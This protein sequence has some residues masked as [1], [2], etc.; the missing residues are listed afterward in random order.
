MTKR[1]KAA[2]TIRS[3]DHA[4]GSQASDHGGP[5][6]KRT[7]RLKST[8]TNAMLPP[9]HA[10]FGAGGDSGTATDSNRAPKNK[11]QASLDA[12]QRDVLP[13]SRVIHSP[14]KK[15]TARGTNNGLVKASPSKKVEAPVQ[16]RVVEESRPTDG[17]LDDTCQKLRELQRRK[18]AA[19]KARIA[20]DNQ[21]TALVAIELGYSAGLEE[22]ERKVLWTQARGV[23]KTIGDGADGGE[24]ANVIRLVGSVV[25]ATQHASDGFDEYLGRIEKEMEGLAKTLPVLAWASQQRGFGLLSLAAIVGEC[26]NIGTYSG[27]AALQSRLGLAPIQHNGVTRMPSTW[28][29]SRGLPAE[30][31]AE[32]GYSPRRRSIMYVIGECLVKQNKGEFRARY[33]Q[34]K[35]AAK[36]KHENWTDGHAHNHAMLLTAKLLVKR[37][38]QRWR[39]QLVDMPPNLAGPK[40]G[41][42]AAGKAA[43]TS[44]KR[45]AVPSRNTKQPKAEASM[46]HPQ[47]A[48][49]QITS[50]P[51]V[52]GKAPKTKADGPGPA[53]EIARVSRAKPDMIQP[54]KSSAASRKRK[55]EASQAARVVVPHRIRTIAAKTK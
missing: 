10:V 14:L 2:D 54:Q 35:E 16:G 9:V 33:D 3:N 37:L 4:A 28:R 13:G 52:L 42:L 12:P 18:V 8:R 1:Q 49:G 55:P 53:K 48:R 38:W 34:S 26:G 46:A 20:I 44:P 22:K 31:W 27:P 51:K 21:L 24:H 39:G 43:E 25:K 40:P 15:T 7:A 29:S 32:A 41:T 11:G 19:L 17:G 23:I 36:A 30:V 6:E 47:A 50:A 45:L 5:T